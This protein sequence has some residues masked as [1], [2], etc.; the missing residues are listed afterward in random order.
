MQILFICS[1]NTC[2]SPMAEGI[3]RKMLQE[4]GL[5][6]FVFCSSAGICAQEGQAVSKYA[7]EVCR[8]IGVDISKHKARRLCPQDVKNS[9]ILAVMSH[10]YAAFLKSMGAY[11]EQII[12]LGNE[13][14]DPFGGNAEK[15]RSCRNNLQNALPQLLELVRPN[16]R[17]DEKNYE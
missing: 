11:P 15:Y 16:L 13:I 5:D 10:K 12:V 6:E 3:F 4:N 8:E 1:G 9:E 17:K 14:A 2:R 7:Q